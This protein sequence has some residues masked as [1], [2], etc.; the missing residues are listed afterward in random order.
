M[1]WLWTVVVAWVLLAVLAAVLLGRAIQRADR[2]ELG[3]PDHL[4][5]GGP[6]PSDR[7]EVWSR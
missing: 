1:G 7:H 6:T 2:E 3:E 4:L 5:R